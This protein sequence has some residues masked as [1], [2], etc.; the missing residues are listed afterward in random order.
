MAWSEP[1]EH[2]GRGRPMSTTAPY[3]L[4]ILLFVSGIVTDFWF[5]SLTTTDGEKLDWGLVDDLTGTYDLDGSDGTADAERVADQVCHLCDIDRADVV[6]S[7]LKG[8][9]PGGRGWAVER[10]WC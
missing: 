1:Q 9:A 6:M 5:W 3:R 8:C 7:F 2:E 4:D 10:G